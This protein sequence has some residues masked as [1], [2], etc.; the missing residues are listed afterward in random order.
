[1][2][3]ILVAFLFLFQVYC[4]QAQGSL[5]VGL[6]L[7]TQVRG[8]WLYN[9]AA[10]GNKY[11]HGIGLGVLKSFNKDRIQLKAGIAY[12][13]SRMN[14]DN[15]PHEIYYPNDA[16]DHVGQMDLDINFDYLAFPVTLHY[17][18]WT[19][20]KFAFQLFA[21]TEFTHLYRVK[22]YKNST[23]DGENNLDLKLRERIVLIDLGLSLYYKPTDRIRVFLKPKFSYPYV[24][25]LY[26]SGTNLLGLNLETYYSF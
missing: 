24:E 7:T 16:V 19:K 1:M 15:I 9:G 13:F 5:A 6:D 22:E 12:K 10:T 14:F 21:G 2:R 3:I 23:Y 20:N 26:V 18:V 17:S 8:M 25:T 4:V 11:I